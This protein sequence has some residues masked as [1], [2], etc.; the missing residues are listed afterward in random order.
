LES[1][2]M[3][4]RTVSL[5]LMRRSD[6][7]MTIDDKVMVAVDKKG[8]FQIK[9]ELSPLFTDDRLVFSH[10]VQVTG[11]VTISVRRMIHPCHRPGVR[12]IIFE[13]VFTDRTVLRSF[14][15]ICDAFLNQY[16]RYFQNKYFCPWKLGLHTLKLIAGAVLDTEGP[17]DLARN[18]LYSKRDDS[19]FLHSS[20]L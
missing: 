10:T 19:Y 4:S 14:L 15:I 13:V 20:S 11:T 3:W 8:G 9:F 6:M 16:L 5:G 18:T 12:P 1:V 17:W 7:A 2:F